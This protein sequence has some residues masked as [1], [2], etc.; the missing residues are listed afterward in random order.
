MDGGIAKSMYFASRTVELVDQPPAKR[1]LLR[2]T[3]MALG[4]DV[5][6]FLRLWDVQMKPGGGMSVSGY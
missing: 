3:F 1:M 6:P 2:G 4:A 5:D